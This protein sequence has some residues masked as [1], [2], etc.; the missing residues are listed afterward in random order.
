MRDAQDF[1]LLGAT[2][3]NVAQELAEARALAL[4]LEA[5]VASL[6]G[7]AG[8]DVVA[9]CQVADMLTQQLDG[10]AAYVGALAAHAPEEAV[11]DAARAMRGVTLSD[12]ARRLAGLAGLAARPAP[13]GDLTL[14]L[15]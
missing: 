15:D 10:L 1:A 14:F 12:Q 13:S 8:A 4:Q 5:L 2:L 11:I 6:A 9:E 3:R 7:N